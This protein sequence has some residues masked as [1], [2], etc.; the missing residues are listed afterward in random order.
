MFTWEFFLEIKKMSNS[1]SEKDA[2]D[3]VL[4][5]IE[6]EEPKFQNSK[7]SNVAQDFLKRCLV[8]NP[9]SRWTANMLW[10][11]PFLRNSSKVANTAKTRKKQSGYI[12]VLRKPNGNLVFKKQSQQKIAPSKASNSSI[13]CKT[14]SGAP[15]EF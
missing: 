10:N 13:D 11:H 3:D 14:L 15:E 5:K 6:F 7:L 8:K 1:G 4:Y 9:S 12:S 2:G